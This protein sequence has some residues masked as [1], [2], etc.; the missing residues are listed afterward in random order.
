MRR[1]EG[2]A[3]CL[4]GSTVIIGIVVLIWA[5]PGEF[6]G[7]ATNAMKNAQKE[8]VD[9]LGDIVKWGLGISVS[10]CGLYG[11]LLLRLRSSPGFTLTGNLFAA[12][13]VVCFA[14]SAY[15]ALI[16][17]QLLVE[18][19]SQDCITLIFDPWLKRPFSAFTDFFV[20]GLALMALMAAL[21]M[22]SPRPP[23]LG[24][25]GAA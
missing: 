16:W 6:P 2:I 22:F 3:A 8:A 24:A 17:R 19:L 10:V 7:C 18:I 15:F 9:Q 4:L 23:N 1:T 25:G 20:A 11:S 5:W 14:W 12:A 21:L 13:I